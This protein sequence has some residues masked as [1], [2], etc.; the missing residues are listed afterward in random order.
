MDY[1]NIF[2][3]FVNKPINVDI[4]TP[5][6]YTPVVCPLH[7]RLVNPLIADTA[8]ITSVINLLIWSLAPWL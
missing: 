3:G 5:L 2:P 1:R 8:L 7:F 6:S 4:H